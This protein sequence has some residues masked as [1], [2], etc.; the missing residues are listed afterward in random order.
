MDTGA[1]WRMKEEIDHRIAEGKIVLE[2]QEKLKFIY[3]DKNEMFCEYFCSNFSI[4]MWDVGIKFEDEKKNWG[5]GSLG[6]ERLTR[7]LWDKERRYD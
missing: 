5:L 2:K 7:N 6:N 3:E 4:W 1:F